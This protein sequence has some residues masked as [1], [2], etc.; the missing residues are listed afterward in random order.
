MPL[1][2][3]YS[4]RGNEIVSAGVVAAGVEVAVTGVEEAEY[5]IGLERR[6]AQWG[7]TREEM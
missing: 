6:E 3:K 1:N 7:R 4:V 5:W 2:P